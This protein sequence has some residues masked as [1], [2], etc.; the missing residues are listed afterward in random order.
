VLQP[1]GALIPELARAAN[2]LLNAIWTTCALRVLDGEAI[3]ILVESDVYRRLGAAS[4][5]RATQML[6][7]GGDPTVALYRQTLLILSALA[8]SHAAIAAVSGGAWLAKE[9]IMAGGAVLMELEF[10]GSAGAAAEGGASPVLS[11]LIESVKSVVPQFATVGADML[12]FGV[13]RESSANPGVPASIRAS[14]PAYRILT[15]R[16][17]K[18]IRVGDSMSVDGADM[19]VVGLAVAAPD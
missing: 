19:F 13:P 4:V 5:A 1:G 12:V 7:V 15:A 3:A 16:E 9:A 10:V 2:A 18:G 14:F 8:V 11:A 17:A 6:Q